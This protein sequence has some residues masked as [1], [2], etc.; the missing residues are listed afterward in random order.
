MPDRLAASGYKNFE[1]NAA[2]FAKLLAGDK[3]DFAHL[4]ED[5]FPRL[6]DPGL[7]DQ[8][9][10][11]RLGCKMATGAG[12]TTVMAMLISWAF[13][14]RGAAPDSTQF[15][16]A[17]LVCAPNLTVRKRL[18][19]LKPDHE[20][21]Y[22]KTFD[23]IPPAYREYHAK[24]RVL[25]TNWHAFAPK[26]PNSEG[27]SSYKIVDK[28]EEPADAF[29]KDRL[30]ELASR[31]PILVLNDEGHHCWRP[32]NLSEAERKEVERGLSK[33]EIEALRDNEEEA[34]VWLAG[35]DK[36]NNC[37]LLGSGKDDKLVPGIVTAIDLSATPF[38]L[39]NS[40]HPEG[41][42]FP[43]L[44]CDFG[45]VDAIECGITKV[46]RLPVK[47]DEGHQDDAGRPDPKYFRLWKNIREAAKPTEKVKNTIRP[48]AVFTYAQDALNTLAGQWLKRYRE[49]LDID[50]QAVPPVMIVVCDTTEASQIFF[51]R[52]SGQ[53]E[54]EVPDTDGK[55]VKKT[56]YNQN[57]LLA[58]L[59]NSEAEEVT[60]RIDSK[61]LDQ[62]DAEGDESKDDAAKRLR[63]I[64]DTVG[65]PGKLGARIRCVVSVS[66]LTE[67]WDANTVSHILG[68]RAFGSQLLC[69]QV[70]GR[71]LR[72]RSYQPDPKTGLL[73]AEYVDVYGIPFSLIPFKGQPKDVEG[74]DPVYTPIF[75]LDD[76]AQFEIRF[77]L[78]ES[79]V[80]DLRGS[81]IRCDVD[82]L[83]IYD[84]TS[85]Y[86]PT[87]VWLTPVRGVQST[88][89][90][91]DSGDYVKQDREEFYKTVR[92]QKVIFQFAHLIMEDLLRGETGRDKQA[93][94][95]ETTTARHHLYPE[96]VDIVTR[97]VRNRVIYKP[98]TDVRELWL[99]VHARN[100]ITRI[101]DGILPAAAQQ[102]RLLPVLNRF[103]RTLSTEDVSFQTTKPTVE[104]TKSHLNRAP[105]LSGYERAAVDVLEESEIVD[106]YTPNGRNI[107][108]TIPY[109]H[110]GEDKNYEPDFIARLRNGVWLVTEIKGAG[111]K[112]HDPDAVPAKTAASNKWCE[113]VSNVGTYGRWEYAFCDA[114]DEVQ[115]KQVLRDKLAAHGRGAVCVPYT[116]VTQASG[117]PGQNCVPVI[118]L[119][120]ISSLPKSATD[121][122]L[123]QGSL[124]CE[125]ATWPDHPQF[126]K[127]M[128]L[129]KVFGDA[130][131]PLIPVGSYCLFR[132]V[133]PGFDPLG[134]LVLVRDGAVHD[135][136]TG[137]VWTVRRCAARREPDAASGAMQ[138]TFELRP[139]NP[140]YDKT[141]VKVAKPE[142]LDVR[143]EFLSALPAFMTEVAVVGIR[144]AKPNKTP[145]SPDEKQLCI[146]E[147]QQALRAAF[148]KSG[149]P[150]EFGFH[151]TYLE[152]YDACIE[153]QFSIAVI[154]VIGGLVT[155]GG[156]L[157]GAFQLVGVV[158]ESWGNGYTVNGQFKR[159]NALVHTGKWFQ[160]IAWRL[161]PQPAEPTATRQPSAPTGATSQPPPGWPSPGCFGK[162]D[163]LILGSVR[164][165]PCGLLDDCRRLARPA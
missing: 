148:A 49:I 103:K 65:K 162:P 1:V 96:L 113:A 27:G 74:P 133:R 128:F 11:R 87:A 37:G 149:H 45:L 30:G 43:W 165:A 121:D 16:N 104:L 53:R 93:Q 136:H 10:L 51:E 146:E 98:G 130:M 120:T 111:G 161:T 17:V 122:D 89:L 164:C 97:Y 141:F 14:N 125:L 77:P 70:V 34:R 78:V 25:V 79:Y 110:N 131:A 21:S 32:K 59:A 76:R 101:R 73:P 156:G 138:H 107:G 22:Y 67:G 119:R 123:F 20:E 55:L 105:I 62:L 36:I 144:F 58:E 100:I 18:A 159:D 158:L 134:K 154:G 71:G 64:I 163:W 12:K 80:Y 5:F 42:P 19:V 137:G 47:D 129:A 72:R 151:V 26:S 132:R 124:G 153:L 91:V 157:A 6:I 39:G 92:E 152:T 61:R 145:F 15:P 29:T 90:G 127:A 24:G 147:T 160:G 35:L 69:E 83:P 84:A 81:G 7:P 57:P 54:V 85:Q 118:S 135:P 31:L 142:D 115:L 66:M 28:G 50:P 112:I 40:G 88:S 33:A 9:A 143:A 95:N 60:I 108:F 117:R 150:A 68:V 99:D 155:L 102:G 75:A 4:S 106:F 116:I 46:P 48:D 94:I 56:I 3:P 44:V 140:A 52:I 23:L 2:N 82:S 126:D 13:C 109:K 63:E 86:V 139:E 41:S 38:Y 114:D 8:L